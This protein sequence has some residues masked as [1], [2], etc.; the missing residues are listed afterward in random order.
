MSFNDDVKK[1]IAKLA[2]IIKV[3]DKLAEAL[4]DEFS[5]DWSAVWLIVNDSL[6]GSF[7]L[8][9]RDKADW[10]DKQIPEKYRRKEW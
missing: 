10:I 1:D 6:I 9:L 2:D 3:E 5:K 8:W 4:W 7:V